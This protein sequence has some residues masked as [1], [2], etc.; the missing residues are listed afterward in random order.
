MIGK[1]QTRSST[2]PNSG[3][4]FSTHLIAKK[5]E[6]VLLKLKQKGIPGITVFILSSESSSQQIQLYRKHNEMSAHR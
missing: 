2:F 4:D 5:I 3:T 1:L 6:T